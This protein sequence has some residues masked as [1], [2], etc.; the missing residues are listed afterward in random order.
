M[1]NP[2]RKAPA[3]AERSAPTKEPANP[4][5]D[6]GRYVPADVRRAIWERDQGKCQWPIEGG[7]ICG[8]TCRAELDHASKPFAK[9]GRILKPEDGRVLCDFHQDVSAR[10]EFGDDLMN[11]YTR[12]KAGTCSEPVAVYA[13]SHRTERS[14]PGVDRLAPQRQGCGSVRVAARPAV[15]RDR[16]GA[17]PSDGPRRR[18]RTGSLTHRAP[19]GHHADRTRV[20]GP[21]HGER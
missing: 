21:A 9:G 16:T 18:S 14:A 11:N 19:P 10:R 17:C 2:R 1:R 13:A 5:K 8:A 20:R 12:P 6:P 4:A 15:R 7:G 3:S